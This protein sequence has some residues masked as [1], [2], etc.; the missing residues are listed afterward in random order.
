MINASDRKT[1]VDKKPRRGRGGREEEV[2]GRGHPKHLIND[3]LGG[4]GG[5]GE[6]QVVCFLL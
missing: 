5:G 2:E 6:S 3:V 1:A 4:G